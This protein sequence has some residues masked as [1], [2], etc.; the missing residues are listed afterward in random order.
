MDRVA[1]VANVVVHV[2]VPDTTAT[3]SHPAIGLPSAV[4]ATVPVASAGE[5]VAVNVTLCPTPAG[6]ADDASVVVDAISGPTGP[7]P[8]AR[9]PTVGS[10]LPA[11]VATPVESSS[12]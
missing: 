6:L 7:S 12:R 9:P 10:R 3:A 2:A 5:T 4:N 11:S 8:I 1:A